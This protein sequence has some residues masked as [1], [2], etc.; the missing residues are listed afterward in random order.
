MIRK[1]IGA[2][3][4]LGL[5][6][7]TLQSQPAQAAE[8]RAM[9]SGAL[10]GAFRDLIPRFE[11]ASGQTLAISWGP[12]SGASPDAIPVRLASGEKPD[13]LIMVE[14]A[15]N[16]LVAKG[17]F[18]PVRRSAFAQSRIGVGVKSGTA[19][20]DVGSVD[21][22]RNALLNARSI[23]YSEGASGV[24]VATE[25]LGKLGIA[26][27]V[28]PKARKITGELVGEAVA[29]GE[30]EIGLQQVSE[31]KAVPGVDYVG[32]LP[33]AVQKA[34]VMVAAIAQNAQNAKAANDFVDFLTSAD[35]APILAKSGL[36]T[37]K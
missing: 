4:A 36:D 7:V 29:R 13:V 9:V 11:Q 27:Q 14:P 17:A 33:D 10:T 37:G 23:G 18:A 20:P 28:M 12:S 32:P 1:T 19:K 15:F 26:D 22:L 34:S 25:L 6:T 3:I 24:Y 8:L 35:A 21:G 2:T 5:A 16:T 30:V 31:L